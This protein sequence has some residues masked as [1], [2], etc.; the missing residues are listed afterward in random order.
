MRAF[1]DLMQLNYRH[2]GRI[3]DP[4]T[5]SDRYCT[6]FTFCKNLELNKARWIQGGYLSTFLSFTEKEASNTLPLLFSHLVLFRQ[7][8]NLER[9]PKGINNQVIPSRNSC[10]LENG[11]HMHFRLSVVR[12]PLLYSIAAFIS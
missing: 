9:A 6:E 2:K 11:K 7:P 3:W 4:Q 8:V 1:Q 10:V 12:S 5:R